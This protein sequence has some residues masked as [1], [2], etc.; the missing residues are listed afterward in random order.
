M[1]ILSH[2]GFWKLPGEKN[3]LAAFERSLRQGFGIE[4]DFRDLGREL[5]ISHNPPD[6]SAIRAAEFFALYRKVSQPALP[7]AL[8]IKADGLQRM[9]KSM[10]AEFAIDNYFVFDM[11]IPDTLLYARADMPYFVRHSDHEPEPVCYDGAAGVW[12]DE[13]DRHWIGED[14][15]SR[16]LAGGK[17]VCIV[18]P[19]LHGRAHL[20]EWEDYL[21]Y[22][23]VV[24]HPGLMLCTDFPE[25]AR[26]FFR[27]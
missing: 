19:E 22:K 25:Q 14:V 16:H 27:L 2:R 1:Q 17:Q 6:A 10:L 12:L 20:P 11:S 23:S 15:I 24:A 9:L 3:S 4:T 13:F 8:N 7:L 5:V 18:S 26:E 21:S